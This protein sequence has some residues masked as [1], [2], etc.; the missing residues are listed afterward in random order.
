MK[1][2]T[3]N[4][5]FSSYNVVLFRFPKGKTWRRGGCTVYLVPDQDGGYSKPAGWDARALSE[6]AK[7]KDV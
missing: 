1:V 5:G 6:M 3:Q 2:G 7:A 4:G